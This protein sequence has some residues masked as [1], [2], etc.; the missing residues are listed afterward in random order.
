[1]LTVAPADVIN[2]A[3]CLRAIRM[4][5]RD[6]L[7]LV[8][9]AAASPIAA[10]AQ[11]S[12]M[13]VIGYVGTGA[14]GAVQELLSAFHR[15]LK[16]TGYV[17]GQ[18]IK[19]EYR[20]AEG[21]YNRLPALAAELV[22]RQVTAIVTTGGSSAALAAKA[23]TNNIPILF[24]AGDDPVETGVVTSLNRP[25][26]NITG[27]TFLTSMLEGKRF[28]LLHELV[29]NVAVIAVLVNPN[30]G[31]PKAEVQQVQDAADRL[32]VKLVVLNATNEDEIDASFATMIR[33]GAPFS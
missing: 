27:V 17:E 6:F 11:Q 4:R 12:R 5:R 30:S 3:L 9:G 21:H 1:M 15:G 18:N 8:G 31:S 26:G 32:K 22:Q 7:T 33:K 25:N 14:P 23:A 24:S 10:R 20:F 29:P 2:F 19:I 16:E 28:E 13:P